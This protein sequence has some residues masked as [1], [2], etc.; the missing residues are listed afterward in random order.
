MTSFSGINLTTNAVVL[1]NLTYFIWNKLLESS[2]LMEAAGSV[3]LIDMK[4]FYGL[5]L[6]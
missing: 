3:A 2:G 1:R 5:T 6:P 4:Y